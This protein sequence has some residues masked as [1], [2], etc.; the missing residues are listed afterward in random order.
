MSDF[1]RLKGPKS[2]ATKIMVGTGEKANFND[3]GYKQSKT[4]TGVAEE[5]QEM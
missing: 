1:T 4:K 5:V 3:T 2:K